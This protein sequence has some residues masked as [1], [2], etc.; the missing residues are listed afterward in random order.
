MGR[1][2]WSVD[3]RDSGLKL[4]SYWNDR[5]NNGENNRELVVKW[6]Y[7]TYEIKCEPDDTINYKLVDAMNSELVDETNCKLDCQV[8][9]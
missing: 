8:D 4:N 2:L 7:F 6:R 3:E 9:Y 5:E 1:E